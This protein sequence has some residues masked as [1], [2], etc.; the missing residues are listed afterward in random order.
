MEGKKKAII[1][2]RVSTEKQAEREL[3]LEAQVEICRKK[4]K[5]LGYEVVKV[6]KEAES[7]RSAEKREEFQKAIDYAI[8]NKI[9]AF[10]VYDTSRF[11]RNRQDA[12]VYKTLLRKKG[13]KLIYASQSIPEED[14]LTSLF[15]EGIL[16]IIDEYYSRKLAK[17]VKRS[18]EKNA[19]EGYWNGG[20]PPFGYR[21]KVI[22]E[23]RGGKRKVKLEINP[24]EASL[25][26]EIYELYLFYG[27][28]AYEIAK[29]L[30]REGKL[31]RGRKWEKKTILRIL[32]NPIYT[33]TYVFGNVVVE[34]FCEPII[35]KEWFEQVKVEKEKR[36]VAPE[37]GHYVS[38]QLLTG[39]IR[40]GHCGGL[41][42][43]EPAKK[44][45]YRYYVCSTYKKGKG[46]IPLRVRA[47][48]VEKIVIDSLKEYFLTDDFLKK[49][50][51]EFVKLVEREEEP[52]REKLKLKKLEKAEA[53]KALENL[54][55]VLEKAPE[56]HAELILRRIA[57]KERVIKNLEK[58]IEELEKK[59][60]ENLEGFLKVSLEEFR[61]AVKYVLFEGDVRRRR[62]VL[63]KVLLGVY[64]KEKNSEDKRYKVLEIQVVPK[65]PSCGE[66]GVPGGT[67]TRDLEI[68][69]LALYPPELRALPLI[70]YYTHM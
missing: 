62:E 15:V 40:C 51:E 22:A 1:Y 28:G 29:K 50:F 63:R 11:A 45:T 10:I 70:K 53:E 26:R 6:F 31:N 64:V 60:K 8:S 54:Y 67:R 20:I 33:G 38:N 5:E 55:R 16:E 12:I 34:N 57:E 27:L 56:E 52:L 7:G 59:K 35:P 18:M 58:E 19:Q 17:D 32:E 23:F 49:V 41:M 37:N 61:E 36:R 30:N 4:A 24:E 43:S 68:R 2:A 39:I 48:V 44:Q 13:V 47:D 66:S 46:C 69:N 3:S 25:V 21:R 42:H 14:D 65:V 9:D